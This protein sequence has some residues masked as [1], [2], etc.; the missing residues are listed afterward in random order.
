MP[1]TLI[2]NA[3]L[4]AVPQ[5]SQPLLILATEVVLDFD[6]FIAD[7]TP[8]RVLWYPEYTKDN[9]R[10]PNTI[11][12]RELAEEDIGNGDIRMPYTQRRF[13]TQGADADLPAGHYF[14]DVQLKRTHAFARIQI[15]GLG[16]TAKVWAP[17][18]EIPNAP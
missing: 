18:G 3:P 7:R 11:W 16:C 15:W 8:V 12:F 17:F 10:D 9:P 13:S 14:F 2:L 4:T 6:L 1:S 5:P